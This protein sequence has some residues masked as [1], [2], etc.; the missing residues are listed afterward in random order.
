MEQ[1]LCPEKRQ[2]D[3]TSGLVIVDG[4][5]EKPVSRQTSAVSTNAA[6]TKGTS[7]NG[8]LANSVS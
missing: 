6:G 1:C 7:Q 3:L 8:K 2:Q 4:L 5:I